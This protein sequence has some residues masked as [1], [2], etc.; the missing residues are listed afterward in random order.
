MTNS[1]GGNKCNVKGDGEKHETVLRLIG[2]GATVTAGESLPAPIK[3]RLSEH[4]NSSKPS[5]KT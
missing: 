5:E 2:C 3:S 1:T 4:L